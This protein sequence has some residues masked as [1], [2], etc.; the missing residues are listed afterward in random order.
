MKYSVLKIVSRSIHPKNS[1]VNTGKTPCL[2]EK[3]KKRL[4][5]LFFLKKI[6]IISKTEFSF[7]ISRF[8]VA[9]SLQRLSRFRENTPLFFQS[10]VR[11][12]FLEHL[13]YERIDAAHIDFLSTTLDDLHYLIEDVGAIEIDKIQF[14]KAQNDVFIITQLFLEALEVGLGIQICELPL[15]RIDDRMTGLL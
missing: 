2:R 9:Q 7:L 5:S 4:K 15:E 14:A 13:L 11:V 1:G 6:L 12:G 8:S 3:S 10:Q